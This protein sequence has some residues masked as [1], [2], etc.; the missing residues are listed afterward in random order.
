MVD[1][2]VKQA[3]STI[4]K[5]KLPSILC[6]LLFSFLAIA[7]KKPN[8]IV[9]LTDDQR[10][11][12]LNANGNKAIL[13]P[14]L[15]KLFSKGK[16]F[17]NA[18]VVFSLCSPSRAALLTGRYG[19]ANGVLELDSKLK[20]GE[21]T[22]A[23]YL[24]EAGYFTGVSGKWHIDQNP[25]ELG[26][27]FATTFHAN[28]TY[29]NRK[30]LDEG[31]IVFPEEHCDLY[32]AR[33]SMDFLEIAAAKPQPFFLFHCTQL[34]HMDGKMEWPTQATTKA[35]YQ[36]ANMPVARNKDDNLLS[37]PSHLKTVR[38]RTQAQMYGY[39]DSNK[40]QTHSL[41]Y[42]SVITEMDDFL[43]EVLQKIKQLDIEDNTYIIFMSDNGWMLGD[44]GFTSKV[45]PYK[46]STHVPM[47]VTGPGI[48]PSEDASLML[49][50]DILPTIL[51]LAKLQ[52]PSNI[53]GRDRQNNLK[54]KQKKNNDFFVYEG[55]GTY[56]GAKPN[57]SVISDRFRYIITYE[58]LKLNQVNFREMYDMTIDPL[59]MINS[60]NDPKYAALIQE[61]DKVILAHKTKIIQL[62]L[63]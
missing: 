9:I 60:I 20:D 56:G 24:K 45:L 14:N 46:A 38:N 53:H 49:N 39:P 21:K 5:K 15:D 13:T 54:G 36:V 52:I 23:Q 34:P 8:F 4:M 35:K 1:I 16:R 29:F 33:R 26:F 18:H 30:I 10:F 19:S 50:I 37:K 58:N 31:K 22:V 47:C 6:L 17:T 51:G 12:A 11:D 48:R 27:D 2:P 44:H 42:Y 40:I 63:Y 43:G 57:L 62:P 28:G 41:D 7:Q 55:L 61:F 59:E 25:K 32:C 3:K